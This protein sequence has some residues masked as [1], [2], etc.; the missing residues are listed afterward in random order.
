MGVQNEPFLPARQWQAQISYQYGSANDFYVGTQRDDSLA[1]PFGVP[2]QRTVHLI[3][4]DVLYGISNR[5][6]LD[7][8]VPFAIGSAAV[9][10]GTEESHGQYKFKAS[11]LGDLTLQAEYWLSDPAIPSRVTGSIGLGFLAPTGNDN[12]QGAT[13]PGSGGGL[14]PVDESAQLGSGG[15]ALLLRA[16]GTAQIHGPLFAYASALYGVSLREHTQVLNFDNV[17]R[18]VPDVYSGRLGAAYVLPKVQGLVVS[19]GGRVNGVTVRDLVGGGDLY[20]R[21]PGYEIYVEPGLTWTRGAEHGHPER[22][23]PRL[24]QQ[25]GQPP[26]CFPEQEDRRVFRP[27]SPAGELRPPLLTP[28]REWPGRGR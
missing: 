5:L 28:C 2:P 26:R 10:L 14:A 11:G 15:W 19:L 25:A 18:A 27:L 20:W 9:E 4:L 22:A 17:L 24:R 23:R 21:R 8:T 16:Q 12:V 1:K 6:S 3:N 7:V 13:S